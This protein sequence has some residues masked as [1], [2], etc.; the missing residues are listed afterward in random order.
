MGK[1]AKLGY[2]MVNQMENPPLG[3]ITLEGDM[4]EQ[5]F[6]VQGYIKKNNEFRIQTVIIVI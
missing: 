3:Q 5:P 4:A 2:M 6:C 1:V